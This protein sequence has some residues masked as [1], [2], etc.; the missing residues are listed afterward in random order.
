MTYYKDMSH[1]YD[2]PPDCSGCALAGCLFVFV[3]MILIAAS[4]AIG[5]ASML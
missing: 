1:T 5:L 4:L 3:L 2:T